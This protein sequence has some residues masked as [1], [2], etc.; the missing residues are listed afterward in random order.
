ML[1]E[2]NLILETDSYKFG[3]FEV[4]PKDTLGV[5]ASIIPRVRGKTVM[6][7]MLV[8]WILHKLTQPITQENIDEA[9]EFARLHGEPFNREG[10]QLV[11]DK[12]NGL[13]PI[14]IRGVPEGMPIKSGL[15]LAFIECTIP[16]LSWLVGWIEASIQRAVWSC[17]TIASRDYEFKKDL[18]L[19]Y[20]NSDSPLE[21]LEFA[22]HDFG[23]RGVTSGESAMYS[24]GAHLYNFMGS[25]TVEGVHFI[26]KAYRSPMSAYSVRATEHYIECS[27]G[28]SSEQES[29][30]LKAVLDKWAKSGQIVSI[31]IDGRDTIRAATKLCTEF[32]DQIIASGAKVVFRPDSGDMMEIVPRIL[33][34]QDLAFG[35][36]FTSKNYKKINNVGV[37]QGDGVNRLN[38]LSLIGKIMAMGYSAN[39]VVFG[40]GGSLLQD[41]TR[42]TFKFAMKVSARLTKDGWI[43]VVKDPITDPEKK[44][45]AGRL[46]I[47]RSKVTGEIMVLPFDTKSNEFESI[48][49]LY[50]HMGKVYN[51]PTI[52]EIRARCKV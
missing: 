41:M 15:P 34:L 42:D 25:D 33:Q 27:Y 8:P 30:Y 3:H 20:E 7:A 4:T 31:V 51:I 18:K 26:N 23:A 19:L 47:F 35:H 49:L 40:S 11:L 14:T 9:E 16:E 45:L 13:L 12:Y 17:S 36:T 39:N 43:D 32:K 29:E 50:Y 28:L 44:S 52:E 37:I 48:T 1:F 6:L 5:H 46:D 21:D 2:R 10:W 38:A 22:L 24:G